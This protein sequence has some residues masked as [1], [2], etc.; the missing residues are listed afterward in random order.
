MWGTEIGG[1]LTNIAGH[2]APTKEL[3]WLFSVLAGILMCKVV[4]V[5]SLQ[6][7][8]CLLVFTFGNVVLVF[9]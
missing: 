5:P 4:S 9:L 1:G 8:A 7:N 6:C 3:H 2:A